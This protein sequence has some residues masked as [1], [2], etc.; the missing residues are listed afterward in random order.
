MIQSNFIHGAI[1]NGLRDRRKGIGG[2]QDRCK[3]FL[4]L[5]QIIN[6]DLINMARE[7]R[8]KLKLKDTESEQPIGEMF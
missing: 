7:N 5:N 2:F 6:Q 4:G 1:K 3:Q 8:V